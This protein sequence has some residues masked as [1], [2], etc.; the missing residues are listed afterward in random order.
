MRA[1]RPR[2]LAPAVIA[3]AEALP[4]DDGAVEAAMATV[5]VHQWSDAQAGVRELRRVARGAVVILTFDGAALDRLWLAEYAPE[6]MAAE[7]RRYPSITDLVAWLG[8]PECVDVH[9]VLVPR[10][11]ADGFTEAFYARPAAFL[12][13]R[14]RAG[15]SAWGFV[16]P[17]AVDRCIARLRADLASG[18]WTARHG[19]FLA[20]DTFEG[21]LRLV[22]ARPPAESVELSGPES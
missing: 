11:C 19:H 9:P 12:D 7:R 1:Q 13:A 5:T 4:L 2:H 8:G 6:L 10:D 3:C 18:A 16:E 14:V 22:V 17:D 15:Q 21:A 20:M